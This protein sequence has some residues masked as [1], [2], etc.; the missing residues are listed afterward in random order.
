MPKY[1]NVIL[2]D[3]D[4]ITNYINENVILDLKLG[5][6]IKT[7]VAAEKALS[8]IEQK[9]D[10]PA[11]LILLDLKMP[12]FDG[13]DFLEEFTKLEPSIK[14]NIRLVVLTTSA[15][16]Q[17][18]KRVKKLGFEEYLLKPLTKESLARLE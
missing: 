12:V 14:N 15:N 13:F 4:E 2:I 6:H 8:D 16:P 7:Y 9:A 5:N 18:M 11:T 1:E 17:D 10:H 3:D